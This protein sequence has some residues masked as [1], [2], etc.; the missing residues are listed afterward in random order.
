MGTE[1]AAFFDLDKTILAKSSSFAFAKPFYKQG[2]IGRSD[3]LRSAYAQFVYLTSGADHDQMQSMRN[4]LSQLVAG[5][6]VDKVQQIVAETLD[7]IVDPMVYQ[8]ALE[9]I[10]AHKAAGHDVIIISASG[11][12]IV[13]P[14]GVRLGADLALGTQ[15]VIADGRYTGEILFYAYG[16]AKA[17]AMS[18]LA[19]ERG[20][21]LQASYAYTDS[22]T[23]VPM[24]ESV[25]YPVAVNP[26]AE[27]RKVA[28]DRGWPTRD[29]AKP[30]AMEPKVDTRQMIAV[31]T[32]VAIGAVALGITWYARRRATRVS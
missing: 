32:G 10:A 2:L 16:P 4:Y 27:L 28:A 7:E 11:T 15:M 24:L 12:D 26:D 8:E 25:G 23:D 6:D 18:A 19:Q 3:V 1:V 21:D 30:V 29:F 22:F 5:W 20:Y 9:L 31:G 17:E 13:E 14:I